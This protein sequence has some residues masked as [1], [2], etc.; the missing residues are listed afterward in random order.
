MGKPVA[1]DFG[2]GVEDAWSSIL[3]FVPKFIGF[4]I[5]LVIGFLI[6]RVLSRLVNTVLERVG[7]DRAVER[8]GV[9]RALANSKYDASDI[10]AKLVYYA[11]VLLTLVVAFNVFGPNPIS[12]LLSGVI[13]YLPNIAVAIIIV[14]VAAA[15]ASAV[16]DLISGALGGL[17]YAKVLANIAAVFILGIGIIAALNQIGIATTVTT[18]V[19]ITVLA[20]IGGILVVGVGGG[21]IR[22]MEQRWHG[23]L[24]GAEQESANARQQIQANRASGNVSVGLVDRARDAAQEINSGSDRDVDDD[25]DRDSTVSTTTTYGGSPNPSYGGSSGTSY[26]NPSG[27][28]GATSM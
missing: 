28:G 19:L 22:P 15:I 27:G 5:I 3:A 12:S 17:S 11:I 16:K 24:E 18:P 9:A 21:L 23:W 1:V 20:T 8:G 10:I 14:V 4:L 13:G 7:F 2:Q 25:L 6:A 26:G